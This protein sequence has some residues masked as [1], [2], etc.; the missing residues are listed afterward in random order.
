ML[1]LNA[2][3]QNSA[4]EITGPAFKI[5]LVFFLGSG[6]A[7]NT[8]GSIFEFFDAFSET[9]HKLRN[10]AAAEKQEHNYQDNDKFR[11]AETHE[12]ENDERSGHDF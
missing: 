6:A 1:D 8:F 11:A 10:F 3:I 12:A 2:T 7:V 5:V 4:P 9:F